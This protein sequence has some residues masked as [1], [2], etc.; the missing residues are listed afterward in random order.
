MARLGLRRGRQGPKQVVS[1]VH[2][3]D[4]HAVVEWAV[5]RRRRP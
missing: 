5:I 4:R 1:E 3:N 2:G